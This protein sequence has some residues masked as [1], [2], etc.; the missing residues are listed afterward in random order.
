MNA[1]KLLHKIGKEPEMSTEMRGMFRKAVVSLILLLL[2]ATLVLSVERD[3]YRLL[4]V[5]ETSKMILVSHL[6]E[7]TKY[8]LDAE[9][10]KITLNGK[11]AEFKTLREFALVRIKFEL[12]KTSKG[13]VDLDGVVSEIALISADS[14]ETPA[15]K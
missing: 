7:K 6:T 13:A 5:T 12:K 14:L 9:A 15:P 11:P 8:L 10:A 1:R 4:S 2:V 3:V